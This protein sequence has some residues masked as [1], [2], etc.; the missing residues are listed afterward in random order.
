[1]PFASM[2]RPLRIQYEGAIDHLMS[3]GDRREALFLDDQDR[4]VF[5]KQGSAV[6][7]NRF[8][9]AGDYEWYPE[10]GLYRC[11]ARFYHPAHARWLQPD[12]IGQAGGLNLYLYCHNDPI[13]GSDPSGL[14]GQDDGLVLRQTDDGAGGGGTSPSYGAQ[15]TFTGSNIPGSP[16]AASFVEIAPV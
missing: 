2:P 14:A 16:V 5:L 8:L 11:G 15:P 12:P 10:I 6:E 4:Q 7:S 1:M 3:R 9:W 13:N